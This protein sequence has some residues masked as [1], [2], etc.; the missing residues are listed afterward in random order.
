MLPPK[1][2]SRYLPTLTHV[3]TEDEFIS[4]IAGEH[5]SDNQSF[6]NESKAKVQEILDLLLPNVMARMR[7]E[8]QASLEAHLEMAE[9]KLRVEVASALGQ[10]V[11]GDES[12]PEP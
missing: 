8:M 9:L 10:D 3:V 2:R 12:L 11:A 6:A 5:A 4:S 1:A 7:E